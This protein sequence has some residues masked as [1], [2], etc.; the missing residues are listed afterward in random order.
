MRISFQ[1]SRRLVIRRSVLQKLR[2]LHAPRYIGIAIVWCCLQA[3]SNL[4]AF[5]LG[6]DEETRTMGLVYLHEMGWAYD[7]SDVPF[8]SMTSG[9]SALTHFCKNKTDHVR[10]RPVLQFAEKYL[11]FRTRFF[12]SALTSYGLFATR[13]ANPENQRGSGGPL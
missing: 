13:E 6:Q 10:P 4:W 12:L 7:D 11:N 3:A 5:V 8:P 1:H 2:S 9:V